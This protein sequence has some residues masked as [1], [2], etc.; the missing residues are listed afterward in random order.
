[1]TDRKPAEQAAPDAYQTL[2]TILDSVDALVYV[3]DMKT[4]EL[5]FANRYIRSIWGDVVGAKCWQSL[6]SGQTGP[7]AFCTN[8]RLL[9]AAGQPTGVY[10]WE[11]QNTRNG[12][13][14]DCRDTALRWID[15]RIVRLE[16]ATD[17]TERKK[18]EEELRHLAISDALTGLFNRRHFFNLAQK[19]YERFRR[20]HRPLALMMGDIDHFKAV[21]DQYGH[22]IGDQILQ[23]VAGTL[24]R[25]L[26]QA[27][28]LARY[29]G[30][31]FAMALPETDLA[32]ARALAERLRTAIADTV[33]ATERGPLSLTLSLGVAAIS[34]G[35]SI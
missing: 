26:R 35:D 15:G 25:N 2:L 16:I 30:E 12:R 32:T 17:I 33:F 1:M 13:W 20:Y 4:Y 34:A 3:A 11:C 21:N 7:C 8:E 9:D 10:Q 6:Q 14:Y 5:L 29:G 27:D 28:I 19:E 22:L 18:M 31:E 23:A 24:Q